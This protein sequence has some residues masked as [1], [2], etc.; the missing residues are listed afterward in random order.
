MTTFEELQE[1][2]R[3]LANQYHKMFLQLLEQDGGVMFHLNHSVSKDGERIYGKCS[4]TLKPD[5]TWTSE[6]TT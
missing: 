3:E 2:E 4:V 1:A 6:P 5:G